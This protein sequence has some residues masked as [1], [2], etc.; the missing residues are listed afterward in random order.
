MKRRNEQPVK[1][2]LRDFLHESG[3]ETPLL[4]YRLVQSW[5][6]VVGE[7]YGS[8]S[9]ALEIR[10]SVLWVRVSV[11]VLATELQMR[12]SQLVESL[13]AQVGASIIRDIRFVG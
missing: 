2:I 7:E 6:T 3:L 1:D 12:R 8:M 9:E 10:D 4:Q 13:N 11:P 5:P